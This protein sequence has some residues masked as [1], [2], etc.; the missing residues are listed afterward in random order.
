MAPRLLH[1]PVAALRLTIVAACCWGIWCSWRLARADFLF[2]RDTE[3]SIRQ[4][5]ATTPDAWTYYTRLAELDPT[6]AQ[7]LLTTAVRL[8]PYDARADIELGLQY[9]AEGDFSKAERRFLR[10][11][12]VDHTYLPRWS[13]A[14]FYF[15]RG[16]MAA[17]W[18]W[19]RSAAEV[20]S[21]STKA[22]FELC[23]RVEPDPSEITR[24]ILNDDPHLL[25][26]YLEFLLSKNQTASAAGVAIRIIQQGDPTTDLPRMYSVINQLVADKDG[27]S[28]KAIWTALMASHWVTADTGLPNNPNFSRNPL[29][30]QFDWAFPST[31]GVESMP[32]P[33]GLEAEFSGLEPD[34]CTIAEQAVVL[35]PGNY[36]MDYS[37]HTEGIAPD[38]GLQW[39][40]VSP[41]SAKPLAESSA[42]S[43]DAPAPAKM[44]FSIP[45]GV[46]LA[47]L[48]LDYQRT[49]G[50]PPIS[51]SLV[52]SSVQIHALP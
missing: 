27:N 24:R 42:L 49:L 17:F 48:R 28:A 45:A 7:E 5:I 19:A 15:R 31:S 33:S 44:A 2:H 12:A 30:V 46:S 6:R 13:L 50:T 29:P 51:G 43:S 11:F 21:D 35:S 4:A 26:Q 39:Q 9:E 38:T 8:N 3:S 20:P 36:E 34:Q 37:Y 40:I 14:G 41:D 16:N 47:D 23:W 22:L 10:A 18:T 52:I 1:L 32:G 25:R